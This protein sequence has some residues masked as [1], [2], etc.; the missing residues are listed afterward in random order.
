MAEKEDFIVEVLDLLK[1]KFKRGECAKQ[2]TDAIYGLFLENYDI[3][4]TP[5]ELSKHYGKTREAVHG[6]IKRRMF[7][8]PLRNV[9]L[10]S[11]KA[12]AKIIP[13]SWRKKR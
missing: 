9:T 5:D 7:E 1:D 8:K 2:Q 10:Y 6:V 12:F 4:V 3:L 13:A 11:F